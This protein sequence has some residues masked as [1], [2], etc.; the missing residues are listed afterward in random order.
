MNLVRA[1]KHLFAWPAGFSR[2][3]NPA[4]LAQI[5]AAIRE[6]E[7][8]HR[9]ELRFCVE[10]SLPMS[11]LWRDAT[12]R[13]RAVALFGKLRVWDTEENNGVLLY[14]LHVERKVELVADR[15]LARKLP[16]TQWNAWVGELQAAYRAGQFEAGTRTVLAS[17]SK[18]L[19]QHYPAGADNPNEMPDA[20]VVIRR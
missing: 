11:Y 18:A 13:E 4:M 14:V 15:H 5:Q 7:T 3:W 6:S 10:E 19:A 9:A 16:Q 2:A 20:P 12:A 8:S 1:L 17:I